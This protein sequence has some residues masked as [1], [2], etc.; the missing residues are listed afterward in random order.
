MQVPTSPQCN[1]GLGHVKPAG[2]AQWASR[3]S[4]DPDNESLVFRKFDEL[5]MVNLLYLQS[6]MLEIEAK[7][8]ALNER[9]TRSLDMDLLRATREWETLIAQ[10]NEGQPRPEAQERMKLIR[11]LKSHI[12]D[13]REW[14]YWISVTNGV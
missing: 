9:A 13:Y 10:C 3:L 5:A 1:S 11:E 2:Y 6:G 12:K 4:S 8:R 7:L 14:S